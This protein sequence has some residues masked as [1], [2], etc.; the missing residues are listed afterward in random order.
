MKA[1][2]CNFWSARQEDRQTSLNTNTITSICFE[3]KIIQGMHSNTILIVVSEPYMSLFAPLSWLSVQGSQQHARTTQI[4]PYCMICSA[5]V[6]IYFDYCFVDSTRWICSLYGSLQVYKISYLS[7]EPFER[8]YKY[9]F[10]S[11]N[12]SMMNQRFQ[13]H[14]R[15]IQCFFPNVILVL[16]ETKFFMLSNDLSYALFGLVF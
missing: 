4:D 15:Y 10:C 9:K 12:K 8:N 5:L 7:V 14:F 3:I 11:V 16:Y 2:G 6:R 13:I 1:Q